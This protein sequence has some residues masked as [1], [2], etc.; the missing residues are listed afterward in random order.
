MALIVAG[1]GGRQ[2]SVSGAV[3]F[4]GRPVE[5]GTLVFEPADGKGPTMGGRIEGGR[6]EV[7]GQAGVLPGKKIVRIRAVRKTGR[8][9]PAGP[10]TPP[11][12]MVDQVE[13][14]IPAIYN[15]E[16]QLTV[17]L[18]PDCANQHDF[19]LKGREKKGDH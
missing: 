15:S 9:V 10:P 13:R 1:C 6:Y 17:Q 7:T 8:R 5:D 3:T 11:G 19:H 14:Y 12:T 4:D 2:I 16:S 18:A